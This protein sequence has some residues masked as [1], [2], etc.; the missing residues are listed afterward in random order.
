MLDK[1]RQWSPRPT[2]RLDTTR[3]HRYRSGSWPHD[4]GDVPIATYLADRHGNYKLLALDLDAGRLGADAVRTDVNTVVRVLT[5]LGV[6]HLVVTSGPTG[7]QHIWIRISEPG[8]PPHTMAQLA[9]QMRMHL[10]TLDISP[11]A[12]AATGAVRIPGSPHREGGAATPVGDPAYVDQQIAAMDTRPAP[13]ELANWLSALFP[14]TA[15]APHHADP[16]PA[17]GSMSLTGHGAARRL[18]RAKVPLSRESAALLTESLPR[19]A[20]RSAA[21]WTVLLAMAASGW[22]WNDVLTQLNQPGLARLRDDYHQRQPHALNQW[23][24]ALAMAADTAWKRA[25]NETTTAPATVQTVI[26][27]ISGKVHTQS[28]VWGRKGWAS[29]ERVLY[30]LMELCLKARTLT[31]D[32]DVRR[33]A[34]SANVHYATAAR[35]LHR[36]AAEGWIERTAESAGTKAATWK[37][38]APGAASSD[39]FTATQV[40]S[41]PPSPTHRLR[42]CRHDVW[43]WRYG[44]GGVAERIHFLRRVCGGDLPSLVIATGYSPA[45]VSS[46]LRR[47]DSFNLADSVDQAW[48]R[49][50]SELGCVGIM[51]ARTRAHLIDRLLHDWWNDELAWRRKRGKRRYRQR[52]GTARSDPEAL[53]LPIAVNA[54]TRY[55]KFPTQA[56]R[57]DYATARLQLTSSASHKVV[58]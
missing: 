4:I 8:I 58:A 57:A 6:A 33:L 39:C 52:K 9:R 55:G 34:E 31:I 18:S 2:A 19:G 37:L 28:H 14:A 20:D 41:R 36:L 45:T 24:K 5:D 26:D 48:D 22:S 3:T 30:A 13:P 53:S 47:L 16:R 7:G 15:E 38:R 23:N 27:A 10:P 56:G 46:W 32:I 51:A 54:R 11:L 44:L 35:A 1:W 25:D 17:I 43:V 49:T 29:A 50:A 42:H 12:N 40:E 21:A